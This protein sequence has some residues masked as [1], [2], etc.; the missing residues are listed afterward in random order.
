MWYYLVLRQRLLLSGSDIMPGVNMRKAGYNLML[1]DTMV[2]FFP[3]VLHRELWF[4]ILWFTTF[5]HKHIVS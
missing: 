5:F 3:R 1:N 2:A 4:Y